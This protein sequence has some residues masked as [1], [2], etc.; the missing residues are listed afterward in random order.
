VILTQADQF[1]F[2]VATIRQAIAA[3]NTDRVAGPDR[4]IAVR[5]SLCGGCERSPCLARVVHVIAEAARVVPA[6][7]DG[8]GVRGRTADLVDGT[9]KSAAL[10]V[11]VENRD[12]VVAAV[13]L[14]RSTVIAGHQNRRRRNDEGQCGRRD[15]N[16]S[17]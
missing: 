1:P 7:D 11:R 5:C 10:Y 3:S 4:L 12:A 2:R 14:S 13:S 17:Q 9:G 15:H 8:I 16:P 6:R